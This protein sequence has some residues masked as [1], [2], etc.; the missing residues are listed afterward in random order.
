MNYECYN[1]INKFQSHTKV[2]KQLNEFMGSY[3]NNNRPLTVR[4][5]EENDIPLQHYW[6]VKATVDNNEKVRGF[7]LTS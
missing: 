2:N 3:F 1:L 4:I 5:R 6:S 7:Y